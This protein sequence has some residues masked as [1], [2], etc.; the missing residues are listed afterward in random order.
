M[1]ECST[2]AADEVCGA[3]YRVFFKKSFD[4]DSHT[5]RAMGC[6]QSDDSAIVNW[7]KFA[8]ESILQFALSYKIILLSNFNL[9]EHLCSY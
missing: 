6:G 1:V 4:L 2:D 9:K 3:A 8:S 5:K 7:P